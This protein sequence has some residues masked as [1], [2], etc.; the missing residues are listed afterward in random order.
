MRNASLFFQDFSFHRGG[1]PYS[2]FTFCIRIDEVSH[3]FRMFF[4]YGFCFVDTHHHK[5]CGKG[6][7]SSTVFGKHG[8]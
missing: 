5:G 1:V 4:Q 8:G 7:G 2:E 3:Q 6:I